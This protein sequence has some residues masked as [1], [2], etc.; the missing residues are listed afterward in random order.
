MEPS[1][2]HAN[3][4]NLQI[5]SALL[6]PL[7]KTQVHRHALAMAFDWAVIFLAIHLCIQYFHPVTY[8]FAVLVIGAG[9]HGLAI[10][11]HDATH[12]RFMKNRKWN[13][14]VTN[15]LIMYPLF[16][17]IEQ[18]RQNHMRHHRHLNTEHDPDWVSKF[19]K[20]EFLF[21]KTKREFLVTLLSYFIL[22]QGLR[23]AVWFLKRFQSPQNKVGTTGNNWIRRIFVLALLTILTIKGWWMYYLLFWVIPYLSTFFMFQYIR[24]VAEHYGEL[25]YDHVLTSTRSVRTNVLERFFIAPH[26]VGYHLEHHLYPGVPFY[27]LPKLHRLLMSHSEYSEK[28]HIT[29]GYWTGL[30]NELG[31]VDAVMQQWP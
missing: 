14:L 26:Q 31:K 7:F 16:T 13:D 29:D 30:M 2:H 25:S 20:K 12:Y 18:Y 6:K 23:D 3:D 11:M 21:P 24:S 19:G 5:D 10:L 15:L 8:A 1:K 17:S 22:Y 27:N 28:A 4:L 9:M